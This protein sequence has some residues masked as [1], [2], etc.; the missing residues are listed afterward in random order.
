M[1]YVRTTFKIYGEK[2]EKVLEGIV[3]TG[4]IYTVIP[5]SILEEIG[6]NPM[7]KRKFVAFDGEVEREIGEAMI[8]LMGRKC[9]TKGIFG[10]SRDPIIRWKDW[11]WKRRPCTFSNNRL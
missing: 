2:G 4:A 8:E 7:E 10:E 6:V 11:V 1:G 9:T 3:D 5:R